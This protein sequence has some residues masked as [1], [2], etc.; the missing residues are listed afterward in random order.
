M[1][2][3]LLLKIEIWNM[4]LLKIEIWIYMDYID[5]NNRSHVGIKAPYI[6]FK[7]FTETEKKDYPLSSYKQIWGKQL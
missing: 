4:L 1:W 2:N 6:D 5:S 3:I 7:K